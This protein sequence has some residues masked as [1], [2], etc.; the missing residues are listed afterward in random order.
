MGSYGKNRDTWL[1]RGPVAS[2]LALRDCELLDLI[3]I[4]APSVPGVSGKR[5]GTDMKVL[6]H[7]VH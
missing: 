1:S 6:L 4:L 2:H 7:M 3:R 5:Y